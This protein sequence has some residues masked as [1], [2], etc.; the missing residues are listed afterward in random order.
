MDTNSS[1]K[2]TVGPIT[3]SN[4]FGDQLSVISS[5]DSDISHEQPVDPKFIEKQRSEK[6]AMQKLP[7]Q[8]LRV[9]LF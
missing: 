8:L 6:A 9:L 7:D 2:R 4:R 3:L 5:Y 1:E